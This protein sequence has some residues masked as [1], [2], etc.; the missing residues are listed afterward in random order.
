[1]IP[2]IASAIMGAV[3]WGGYEIVHALLKSNLAGVIISI[4]LAV[5]VYGFCLLKF[6]CFSRRELYDLPF[7]ARIVRLA[8]KLHLL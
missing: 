2:L 3:A 7:G 6:H 4:L 5:L 8:E 1:M